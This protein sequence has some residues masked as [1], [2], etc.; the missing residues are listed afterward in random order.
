MLGV[1][2]PTVTLVINDLVNAGIVSTSRG[3]VRIV[4][5]GALESRACECYGA[6]PNIYGAETGLGSKVVTGAPDL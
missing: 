2:R 4:D 6:V 3:M 1:R 5:R